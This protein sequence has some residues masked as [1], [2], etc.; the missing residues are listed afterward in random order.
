MTG[1]HDVQV[2][3]AHHRRGDLLRHA[4]HRVVPLAERRNPD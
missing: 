3:S 1:K 2:V 4:L